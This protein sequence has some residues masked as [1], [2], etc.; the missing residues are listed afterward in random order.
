MWKHTRTESY[1]TPSGLYRAY[2]LDIERSKHTHT[3]NIPYIHLVLKGCKTQWPFLLLYLLCLVA[4]Q[5]ELVLRSRKC[6]SWRAQPFSSDHADGLTGFSQAVKP[7]HLVHVILY[8]LNS[9]FAVFFYY[10]TIFPI[11]QLKIWWVCKLETLR[12]SHAPPLKPGLS[13]IAWSVVANRDV[14]DLIGSYMLR[15]KL[16]KHRGLFCNREK[17]PP[18]VGL[19]EWSSNHQPEGD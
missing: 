8:I 19:K 13:G 5:L 15:K 6:S 3:H 2:R 18:A 16:K 17:N 11:S 7:H 10:T 14:M 4:E 1:T 9:L 12:P